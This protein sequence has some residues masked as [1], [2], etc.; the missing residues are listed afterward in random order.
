MGST[1]FACGC[2][3][4]DAMGP[5]QIIYSVVPCGAHARFLQ[6]ELSALQTAMLRVIS[7]YP[8]ENLIEAASGDMSDKCCRLAR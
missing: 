2:V 7:D 1:I 5:K 6:V 4:V 3:I 8:T